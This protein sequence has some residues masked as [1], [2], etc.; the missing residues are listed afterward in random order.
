MKSPTEPMIHGGTP[1]ETRMTIITRRGCYRVDSTYSRFF[2]SDAFLQ[3]VAH[4]YVTNITGQSE[5][6]TGSGDPR[7]MRV[8]R[9]LLTRAK[10]SIRKKN[11]ATSER[12]RWKRS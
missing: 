6:A 3:K 1:S 9:C 12:D 10:T 4:D 5:Q 2:A 8:D 11:F 7:L